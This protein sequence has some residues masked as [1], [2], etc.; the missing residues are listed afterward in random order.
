MKVKT[1]EIRETLEEI[2]VRKGLTTGEGKIHN[3]L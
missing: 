2:L 1:A 3:L